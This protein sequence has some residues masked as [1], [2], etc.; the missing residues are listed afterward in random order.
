MNLNNLVVSGCNITKLKKSEGG[1]NTDLILSDC[2][3]YT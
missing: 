1:L 3:V 2:T